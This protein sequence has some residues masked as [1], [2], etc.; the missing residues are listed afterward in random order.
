M[1]SWEKARQIKL[2]I[3]DVDGVLTN[4]QLIFSQDGEILKVFHSQDGLGINA[5]HKAGLRTA[6]ITGRDSRMVRRRGEELRI[7][8]IYMGAMDKVTAYEE[9]LQKHSLIPDETAYVGDDL[10]DLAV[11]ARVGLACAVGNAVE[12]V[13]AAAHYV[14]IKQGGRGGVR[15]II[16]F[17]LKNQGKWDQ[18]VQEYRGTGPVLTRQ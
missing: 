9:L 12:E 5:A 10:N 15:E 7:T 3:F 8:D 14:A 18:V 6:I 13:K 17:I 11:M 16:E 1:E 2:L 4:N